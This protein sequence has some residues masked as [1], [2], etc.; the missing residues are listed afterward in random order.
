M[1]HGV[2][3]TEQD[4]EIILKK[5]VLGLSQNAVN[6]FIELRSDNIVDHDN[7]NFNTTGNFG[8]NKESN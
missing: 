5:I 2:L 3:F 6:V 1:T 7:P 4:W 8:S